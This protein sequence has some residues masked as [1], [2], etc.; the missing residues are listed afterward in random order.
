MSLVKV[1]GNASGTGIFTVAA[2]NSNTDRTLTLPDATGTIALQ[3]GT[4]VGKVLQVVSTTLTSASNQSDSSGAW[5][6]TGLSVSI[7]PTQS[8]SKVLITGHLSFSFGSNGI[9]M[10]RLVRGSTSICIGD[11]NGSR[12]RATTAFDFPGS[13]GSDAVITT[14]INFLDSPATTSSTTYKLQWHGGGG[15]ALFFVNRQPSWNDSDIV[16]TWTST[17]TAMEIAA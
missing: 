5:L 4:G 17:L 6:D 16:A 10:T 8:S 15:T 2:P 3:G 14:A 13:D 1:Q 7:T 11:A 9:G 12:S